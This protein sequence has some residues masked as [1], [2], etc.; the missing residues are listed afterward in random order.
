MIATKQDTTKTAARELDRHLI[1]RA[2]N[3]LSVSD[4]TVGEC[5]AGWIDAQPGRTDAA[6]GELV[7]LSADQIQKRRTVASQLGQFRNVAELA[8]LKFGHFLAVL[9]APDPEF[10]LRTAADN[11]MKVADVWRYRRGLGEDVTAEAAVED[12][13]PAGSEIP[14]AD[15][16]HEDDAPELPTDGPTAR[17]DAEPKTFRFN[18]KAAGSRLRAN[19]TAA[20]KVARDADGVALVTGLMTVFDQINRRERS[21]L[22]GPIVSLAKTLNEF[23]AKTPGDCATELA[24]LIATVEDEAVEKSSARR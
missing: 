16:F 19:V 18:E 4:W 2:I 22:R 8:D 6:F 13:P 10:L 24:D 3:A 7:G 21:Q 9:T 15:D 5:A 12:S 11:E 14:A 1:E 20:L 23:T 17:I